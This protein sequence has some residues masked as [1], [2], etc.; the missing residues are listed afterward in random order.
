MILLLR[1]TVWKKR[2]NECFLNFHHKSRKIHKKSEK[3]AFEHFWLMGLTIDDF[4][5]M[6]VSWYGVRCGSIMVRC[7]VLKYHGTV[8]GVEVMYGVEVVY[9]VEVLMSENRNQ[10]S[11][12][13]IGRKKMFTF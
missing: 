2:K 10:K 7:T 13:K 11:K 5:Y 8:Y 4:W 1:C 12:S 9:G 3:Y 6:K